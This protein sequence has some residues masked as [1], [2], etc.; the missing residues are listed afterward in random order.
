MKTTDELFAGD[1]WGSLHDVVVEFDGKS[2]TKE[3]IRAIFD[4]LP[5]RMRNTAHLWGL[6]DTVFRDEAYVYL[7]VNPASYQP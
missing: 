3:E 1:D 2:R 5:E 7:R 6:S 4:K